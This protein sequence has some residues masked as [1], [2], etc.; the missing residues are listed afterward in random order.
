MSLPLHN[1]HDGLLEIRTICA[2]RKSPKVNLKKMGQTC[3]R[4]GE[5][6]SDMGTQIVTEYDWTHSRQQL[7]YRQRET[8]AFERERMVGGDIGGVGNCQRCQ[9]KNGWTGGGFRLA[10]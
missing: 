6:E 1:V 10:E 2:R 8:V 3:K 9:N 4:L 5:L 7:G